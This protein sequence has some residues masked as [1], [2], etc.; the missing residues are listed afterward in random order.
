MPL[1]TY[2]LVAMFMR[3]WFAFLMVTI[4]LRAAKKLYEGLAL[5]KKK[6]DALPDAG[7]IGE[8][9]DVATGK[10]Y[11]LPREGLMGRARRCDVVIPEMK[12]Q[13]V[14]FELEEGR[15][16]ALTALRRG[17]RPLLDEEALKAGRYALHGSVLSVGDR[18][19]RFRLFEG[20]PVPARQSAYAPGTEQDMPL[21]PEMW[22]MDPALWQRHEGDALY[23]GD[24]GA[25]YPEGMPPSIPPLTGY[26]RGQAH[27]A[28]QEEFRG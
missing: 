8:V 13:R 28:A 7:L 3:Y 22:A 19:L 9:V 1:E 20:V 24:D 5:H 25:P 23:A 15:G 18:R 14:A 17:N 2:K 26:E 16:V 6:L 4:T 11:P 10:A 12:S 27:G 21:M